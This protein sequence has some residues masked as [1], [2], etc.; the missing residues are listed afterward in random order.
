MSPRFP[1]AEHRA[2]RARRRSHGFSL[3]ESLIALV[4]TAFGLLAIAGIGMKLTHSED[5]ARQRGEATRLA[6]EKIEELRSFTQM[7]TAPGVNAWE[8]LGGASTSDSIGDSADYHSN[9]TFQ[10]SWQVLDSASDP[11]RRVQVT[12]AWTDR[13]NSAP[14]PDTTLSFS[15]II[16]KTDPF[17]SGAL[18]F[19]LPGNTTIKRPKNRNLNIPV[20]AVDLGN[21]QSVVQLNSNF[22]VVF[23]ND[24]GYVVLTCPFVVDSAEDLSGCTQTNAYILAGYISL[25]GTSSFPTGLLINTL[26]LSNT[27][28][29]TCSLADALDQNSGAA[30]AGYKYYLCVI[31]VPAAGASW[32]GTLRLGGAGLAAGTNYLV[33]RFQYASASGISAN[34][35][36]V[37]AYAG[38][39]ESLDNQNY[40]ITTASSCP[41]I[42]SLATTQHQNCRSS[43]PNGN[44]LNRP[45]DCPA[46]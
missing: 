18:G 1:R 20:P 21:G 7:A 4:V 28:G 9:T 29:V 40:V 30:I 45:L 42:T 35:R 46:L 32:S 24:S 10:R 37:Q 26:E 44:A 41:T 13:V 12:V 31:S 16:S 36:N 5:V 39:G 38:V 17:D 3:I 15:S 22:A 34:Q 23:S 25:N 2:R 11:W 27:A 33:C 19:P 8:T 14:Q 6:Q 43:N